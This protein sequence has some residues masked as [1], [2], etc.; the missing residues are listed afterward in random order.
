MIDRD[1]PNGTRRGLQRTL[2][3]GDVEARAEPLGHSSAEIDDTA[4]AC[5]FGKLLG[6]GDRYVI[7]WHSAG[8][9]LLDPSEVTVRG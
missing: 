5:A 2:K 7:S 8:I 9:E 3:F 4:R 6:L 1:V